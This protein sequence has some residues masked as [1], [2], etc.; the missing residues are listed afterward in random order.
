MTGSGPI[1]RA[2]ALSSNAQPDLVG[3][4]TAYL[5]RTPGNGGA[6]SVSWRFFQIVAGLNA[7]SVQTID[8]RLAEAEVSTAP[9]QRSLAVSI[10]SRMDAA[11][12]ASW[13]GKPCWSDTKRRPGNCCVCGLKA[14]SI[15]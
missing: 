8:R 3:V 4:I 7:R 6:R 15:P 5:L 2:S 9:K 12:M 10:L 14:L 1:A 13:H 11:M